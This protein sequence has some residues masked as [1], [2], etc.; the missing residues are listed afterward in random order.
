MSEGGNDGYD[1]DATILD[2]DYDSE[3]EREYRREPAA[4]EAK[5]NTSEPPRTPPR[6]TYGPEPATEILNRDG[7]RLF[8]RVAETGKLVPYTTNDAKNGLPIYD[9]DGKQLIP[10]KLFPGGASKSRRR[11]AK[12]RTSR[13]RK[14]KRSRRR[15]KTT[16]RYRK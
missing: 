13:R 12:K 4:Q 7:Q 15:R 5:K 11:S 3:Y 16:R 2:E 6:M 10:K 14:P 1:T 8:A 9:Q